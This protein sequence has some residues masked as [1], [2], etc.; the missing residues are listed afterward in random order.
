MYQ[1]TSPYAAVRGPRRRV[2]AR[3]RFLQIMNDIIPWVEWLA[4]VQRQHPIPA[5][6][7]ECLLR[8]Y[9][10]QGWFNLTD[11]TVYDAICDSQSMRAFLGVDPDEADLPD[12][13]ALADFR[14]AL[15][16]NRASERLH[17]AI[18]HALKQGGA[19]M[20]GGTIVEAAVMQVPQVSLPFIEDNVGAR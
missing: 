6:P 11:E 14:L 19:V 18:H 15:E 7:L 8:I 20:R 1:L 3:E 10:L 9:L 13:G 12:A 4:F 5:G 16:K 17:F 2:T